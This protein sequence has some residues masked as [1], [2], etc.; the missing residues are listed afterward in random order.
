MLLHVARPVALRARAPAPACVLAR[1]LSAARGSRQQPQRSETFAERNDRLRESSE[2][3]L[4]ESRAQL[5]GPPSLTQP[6]SCGSQL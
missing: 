1:S 4:E 5:C 2:A 3:K 6:R